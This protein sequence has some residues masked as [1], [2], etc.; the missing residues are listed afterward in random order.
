MPY[1]DS[2]LV[3]AS[4][5]VLVVIPIG[6]LRKSMRHLQNPALE[7]K[8]EDRIRTVVEE[9]RLAEVLQVPILRIVQIASTLFLDVAFVVE[10]DRTDVA[11]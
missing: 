2:V 9:V 11:G 4:A 3:I 10:P 8:L 6:L 5:L 7:S 1:V